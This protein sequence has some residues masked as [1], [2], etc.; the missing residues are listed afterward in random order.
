MLYGIKPN[1]PWTMGGAML[2]LAAVAL[3]ASFIP[4]RKA[5]SMHPMSALRD[6]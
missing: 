2:L 3:T 5:A 4:A 6:D 1:D